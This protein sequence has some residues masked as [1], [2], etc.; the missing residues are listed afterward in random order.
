M[1][2]PEPKAGGIGVIF[3]PDSR[4]T[5]VVTGDHLLLGALKAGVGIKSV[6]GGHGKCGSCL[7]NVEAAADGALSP[8][9]AEEFDLLPR[10]EEGRDYRLACMA[11]VY[12]EV[13]VSI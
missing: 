12:G 13:R 8:A 11:H 2:K 6:C 5:Q 3:L 9:S 1:T 7:V 4:R 10:P